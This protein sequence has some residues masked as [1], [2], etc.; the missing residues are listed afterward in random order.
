[1]LLNLVS[2]FEWF[3]QK[4][5]NLLMWN[6]VVNP[7]LYSE[8]RQWLSSF[9]FGE[10]GPG[11]AVSHPPLLTAYILTS[12]APLCESQ[13]G[14]SARHSM[15][16]Q[17]RNIA[18]FCLWRHAARLHSSF[19]SLLFPPSYLLNKLRGE[20]TTSGSPVSPDLISAK[21]PTH[22]VCV[23]L[24]LLLGKECPNEAQWQRAGCTYKNAYMVVS[25]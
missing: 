15:H 13:Q 22:A 25:N 20:D 18:W 3:N 4:S 12:R 1:M 16:V 11:R 24:N 21:L 23:V 9:L 6:N 17:W 19:I 2:I 5:I 7:A 14:A 8:E 10:D